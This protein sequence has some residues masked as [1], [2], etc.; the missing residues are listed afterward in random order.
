MR[1]T[2]IYSSPRTITLA[3][4][5]LVDVDALKASI[6][7]TASPITYSVATLDGAMA[8]PGPAVL[9]PP[10]YV[11][12]TTGSAVGSYH[13]TD[14][15]VVTGTRG[16]ETVTEELQLT[17][18]GGGETIQGAQPFDTVVSIACPAQHDTSGAWS[19]GVSGVATRCDRQG[20]EIPYRAVRVGA[21]AGDVKV[22]YCGGYT[23]VL[24]LPANTREDLLI[25]RLFGAST[26][27][28]PITLFW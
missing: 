23:D 3:T 21:T 15:H 27:A 26:T 12:I 25:S 11:T 13:V 10:R 20:H 28:T 7:T 22:G 1:G 18:T 2:E 19:F 16:G 24:T 4:A 8:N 5:A 17:A 9:D 14:P 6:A